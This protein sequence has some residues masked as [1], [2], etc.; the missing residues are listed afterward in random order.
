MTT[1]Y[2]SEFNGYSVFNI[3]LPTFEFKV[4]TAYFCIWTLFL[5]VKLY[6][7]KNGTTSLFLPYTYLKNIFLLLKKDG[8]WENLFNYIKV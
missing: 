5:G 3:S 7:D 1:I 4:F 2:Y 6:W 8:E